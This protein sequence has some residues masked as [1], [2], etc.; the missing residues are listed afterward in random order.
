VSCKAVGIWPSIIQKKIYLGK[1]SI[2]FEYD[3]R[4]A[5]LIL[6]SFA[7]AQDQKLVTFGNDIFEKI[8]I[9]GVGAEF[10]YGP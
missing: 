5:V 3:T 1:I 2:G 4:I 6:G 9:M 10:M 7:S 8:Y